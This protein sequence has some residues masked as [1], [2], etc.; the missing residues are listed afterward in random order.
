MSENGPKCVILSRNASVLAFS[1]HLGCDSKTTLISDLHDVCVEFLPKL[2]WYEVKKYWLWPLSSMHYG[3]LR[4][5]SGRCYWLEI[6]KYCSSKVMDRL[7][8]TKNI[9]I[10]ISSLLPL[11][12]FQCITV[13]RESNG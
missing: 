3:S 11:D 12:K 6:N 1:A 8:H 10:V 5:C 7:I 13:G 4:Y 2:S 9:W